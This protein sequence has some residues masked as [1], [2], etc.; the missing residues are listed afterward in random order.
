MLIPPKVRR[1]N[2]KINQPLH[3]FPKKQDLSGVLVT[4]TRD[5]V[6]HLLKI[7]DLLNRRDYLNDT[8]AEDSIPTHP[9]IIDGRRKDV[10]ANS[11]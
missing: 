4:V 11:S 2:H 6:T 5:E 10:A 9:G 8:G 1:K 3:L 7:R